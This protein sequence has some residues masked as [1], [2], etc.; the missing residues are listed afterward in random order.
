[1]QHPL[2]CCAAWRW[3][4]PALIGLLLCPLAAQSEE[5]KYIAPI[6]PVAQP[7][8]IDGTISA[9]EWGGDALAWPITIK[10][11][12]TVA[13]FW[14]RY[15]QQNLYGAFKVKSA[16]PAYNKKAGTERWEG[17]QVEVMLCLDG[18]HHAGHD[19]F[20]PYDY[21]FLIGQN[22][23][24]QPDVYVN[25]NTKKR[26]YLVAGSKAAIKIW[27]DHKGYDLEFS[28]P[29]TEINR[30]DDFQPLP[31]VKV[32]LQF[33]LDFGTLDGARMSYATKWWP[34]GLHFQNP[35]SWA[36]GQ[37]MKAGE[38]LA[39]PQTMEAPAAPP[40][41]VIPIPYRTPADGLVSLNLMDDSGKL[42]RRLVIGEKLAK[43]DHS[44][45]WDGKDEDGKPVTP[46]A[47]TLKGSVAN[48][49]TRYLCS[50]ANS[51][52][53]PY[54]GAYYEGTGGE[55]R[56]GC[57]HDVV[58]CADGSFYITNVGGEGSPPLQQIDPQ[59]AFRV[60]WGG[61]TTVGGNAFQSYGCRDGNTLYFL[62]SQSVQKEQK[63]YSKNIFCRMNNATHKIMR[64]SNG[65]WFMQVGEMYDPAQV[66]QEDIRGMGAYQGKVYF[67]L[68]AENCIEVHDGASGEKLGVITD[69]DL[70]GPSDI[71]FAPDGTML[72]VDAHAVHAFTPEG[73]YLGC[74]ISGL[75]L[76]WS[77]ACGADGKIYVSDYGANQV[78]IYDR[79]G[80]LLKAMG[81]KGGATSAVKQPSLM[82]YG[83]EYAGGKVH[84]D[85]FFHPMGLDV[86]AHGN[87]A[88]VDA[89]NV[90]VQYFS[91]AGKLLKSILAQFYSCSA[92][93]PDHLDTVFVSGEPSVMREYKV[94]WKTGAN[95]LVGNYA[96]VPNGNQFVKYHNGKPYFF[97]AGAELYHPPYTRICNECFV[98]WTL[99]NGQV[100]YSSILSPHV[101]PGPWAQKM[102]V[103]EKGDMKLKTLEE[104]AKAV[105]KPDIAFYE[106]HDKNGDGL[107]Q[108]DEYTFY[109]KAEIKDYW[110][111]AYM[112]DYSVDDQWNI[113]ERLDGDGRKM[114][115]EIPCQ[116]FDQSGAPIYSWAKTK[117][118]FDSKTDPL[119]N[120]EGFKYPRLVGFEVA[121]DRSLYVMYNDEEGYYPSDCRFRRYTPDGKRAWSICRTTQGF[122]HKPGT[123]VSLS[124]NVTEVV[125]GM[126]GITDSPGSV[127][128]FNA[129]G[130][131]LGTLLEQQDMPP[132]KKGAD[133][134]YQPSG[135]MWWAHLVKHPK[136]GKIYLA[137]APNAEPTLL[138]YEV[139]GADS[140]QYFTAPYQVAGGK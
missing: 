55:Y 41:R 113:L 87:L 95:R 137:A 34:H 20:T 124:T 21:Q 85:W 10:D 32:G 65:E 96:P 14:L 109:S 129:D 84:D 48:L 5:E 130:L 123:E 42:I 12:G 83:Q 3:F 78:L 51:S 134:R 117:L 92:F 79:Y 103:F 76:G 7:I 91:S 112:N 69:V 27:P 44:V 110:G 16:N 71:C 118:L 98:V 47:G 89:G 114:V 82:F 105:G 100:R 125:D 40:A 43:G 136:T 11:Y 132:D 81:P 49:S 54:G 18:A 75:T 128:L 31:G 56:E 63:N 46:G 127:H 17:D 15:D 119:W 131:Y 59:H 6:Y 94:D 61:S 99:D 1:M 135:E 4:F 133:R 28:I 52:P 90:R 108:L 57:F 2:V 116:G 13:S 22:E 38:T 107:T 39:A 121:P 101:A 60:A 19:S 139:T 68:C 53:E 29:W 70:H 138:L 120:A 8:V 62:T 86:D 45:N 97:N 140:V 9:Q 35:N 80:K 25:M 33:Q 66:K 30:P 111:L 126:V 102:P 77:V 88:V 37:F 115:I 72:V 26:D 93:D 122:W 104:L 74:V 50:L 58:M 106:W 73:A 67:P 23:S 64:F 36:W 24:G